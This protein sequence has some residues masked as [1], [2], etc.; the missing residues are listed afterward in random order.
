MVLKYNIGDEVIYNGCI[1]IVV[2]TR[3]FPANSSHNL[4]VLKSQVISPFHPMIG[5]DSEESIKAS[6]VIKF[7]NEDMDYQI[8]RKITDVD[9]IGIIECMEREI[10]LK[11]K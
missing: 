9:Y 7:H 10:V 3:K 2:G 11:G 1:Y 5:K 6:G 8:V 4:N